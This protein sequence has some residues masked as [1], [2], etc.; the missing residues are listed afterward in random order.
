MR[1]TTDGSISIRK[2]SSARLGTPI[3]VVQG[4]LSPKAASSAA[5]IAL[6]SCMWLCLM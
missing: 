5:E 3:Q 1:K 6:P 4:G 2:S